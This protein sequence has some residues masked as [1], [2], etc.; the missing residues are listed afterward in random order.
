MEK[1]AQ[2]PITNDVNGLKLNML[3][4]D[5]ISITH[6]IRNDHC[7]MDDLLQSIQKEGIQDPLLVNEIE[8][9]KYVI[10]DGVRRFTAATDMGWKQI[11]CLIKKGIT[12]ADAAHL[13]WVKNHERKSLSPMDEAR[14]LLRMKEEFGFTN[15]E[16]YVK[17]YGS[18]AK[19]SQSLKLLGLAEPVQVM[20]ENGKLTKEHGIHLSNLSTAK[21]QERMAKKIEDFNWS[22]KQTGLKVSRYLKKD[23]KIKRELPA[24]IIPDGDVPGVYFKDSSDMSELPSGCVDMICTSPPYGIGKEFEKGISFKELTQNMRDVMLECTRVLRPGGIMALNVADILNLLGEGRQNPKPNFIMMGHQ[25]QSWLKRGKVHLYNVIIW[26][27]QLAY[28]RAPSIPFD[29]KTAHTAYR[30][31]VNWEPIYIFRKEGVKSVPEAEDIL[32]RSKLTLEQFKK[33][34]NGVWDIDAVNGKADHPT[35]WPEVLPKRLIKMFSYEGDTVLDPF[36]GSGTTIKVAREL[37]REGIGYERLPQYKEVI[38]KKLGVKETPA[39][40]KTMA[41]YAKQTVD[42]SNLVTDEL[43]EKTFDTPDRETRKSADGAFFFSRLKSEIEEYGE[44]DMPV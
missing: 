20:I 25:Y 7:K 21:E 22:A 28:S 26:R 37:G 42:N 39:P 41:G 14:H 18:S 44:A 13:S 31:Y 35:V 38:M 8:P 24:S 11:P 34:S 27:K 29:D 36:L 3:K 15:E 43:C 19:I 10:I 1:T 30:F 5:S 6:H 9:G 2:A 12:A 32:S 17:G 23:N 40:V 4:I 16:L 33:W